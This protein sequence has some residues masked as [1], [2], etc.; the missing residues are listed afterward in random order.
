MYVFTFI[1]ENDMEHNHQILVY[2]NSMQKYIDLLEAFPYIFEDYNIEDEVIDE[3]I[4]NKMIEQ[5]EI[6][7]FSHD[8]IPPYN[9]KDLEYLFKF[10]AQKN[11]KPLFIDFDEE[12]RQKVNISTIAKKIVDSDMRRSEQK[13]YID[14][15]WEDDKTLL[16]VYFGNKYFLKHQ[17]EIEIDKLFE[18]Y[19]VYDKNKNTVPEE[20]ELENLPLN[21]ISKI[22]P[23]YANNIK[24]H[25]FE[26]AKVERNKYRCPNC[27]K[28]LHK[29]RFHIDHIIPISK[30]GKTVIDNLQLLCSTCNRKKGDKL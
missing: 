17:L 19:P 10:Y 20:I 3:N 13:Q 9:R 11:S 24:K 7:Y 4:L 1:D 12:D 14:S 15:L 27:D 2:N 21:E 16:K 5:C 6:A 26:G 30:G 29:A 22:N 18:D 28:I 25:I 23:K 8:M